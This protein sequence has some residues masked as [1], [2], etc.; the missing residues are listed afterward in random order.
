MRE[1][2]ERDSGLEKANRELRT[3]RGLRHSDASSGDI[4]IEPLSP[5]ERG[6][7][8]GRDGAPVCPGR[9]LF[10]TVS[11]TPLAWG[12]GLKLASFRAG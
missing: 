3:R 2:R 1:G 6:G 10:C 4:A 8:E 9:D 5:R 11:P 7:G 12:E